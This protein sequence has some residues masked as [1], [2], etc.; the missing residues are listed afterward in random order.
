MSGL[1]LAEPRQLD[2]L[3]PDG[4][5]YRTT[6]KYPDNHHELEPLR[7]GNF[8]ACNSD[9][10]GVDFRAETFVRASNVQAIRWVPEAA[11]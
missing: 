7:H 10:R 6:E 8:I 11:E 1:T 4:L 2:L 5:W 9:S 3:M